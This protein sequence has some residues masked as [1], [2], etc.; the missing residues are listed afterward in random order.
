M[1]P[2]AA[3]FAASGPVITALYARGSMTS[4]F[5]RAS[6]WLRAVAKS[7]DKGQ[8]MSSVQ[9]ATGYKPAAIQSCSRRAWRLR[10]RKAL[11]AEGTT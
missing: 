11:A 7:G 8:R 1:H 6:E 4:L 9:A 10:R 2:P 5:L 3:D